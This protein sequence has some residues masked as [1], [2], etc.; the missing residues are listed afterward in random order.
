MKQYVVTILN[1]PDNTTRELSV[2]DLD[3]Y[4]AHKNT[5]MRDVKSFEEIVK[6]HNSRGDEVFDLKRGFQGK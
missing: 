2:R 6:M 1:M 3:V 5:L 4:L